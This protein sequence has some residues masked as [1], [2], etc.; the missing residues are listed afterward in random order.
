MSYLFE[1]LLVGPVV[2][3]GRGRRWRLCV[4]ARGEGRRD[5]GHEMHRGALRRQAGS[6]QERGLP[7][8][9][10]VQTDIFFALLVF[11]H[12]VLLIHVLSLIVPLP[13]VA[14]RSGAVLVGSSDLHVWE[15]HP[16]GRVGNSGGQGAAHRRLVV[17]ESQSLL[18][19]LGLHHG[20]EVF[21]CLRLPELLF[22]GQPRRLLPLQVLH[23]GFELHASAGGLLGLCAGEEAVRGC[24]GSGQGKAAG[25]RERALL[26][27]EG[28]G[29]II[30][31]GTLYD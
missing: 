19:D 29:E 25:G 23:D 16:G 26:R 28:G 21:L 6:L 3:L 2:V 17:S 7:V 18:V 31:S 24:G 1:L 4:P 5:S 12:Q 30:K 14:A 9:E 10:V 15:R 8:L 11:I 20:A 13:V 22:Q 27:G